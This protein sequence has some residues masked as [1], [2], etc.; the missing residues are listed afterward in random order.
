MREARYA[1]TK[2]PRGHP[3]EHPGGQLEELGMNAAELG[4]QLNAPSN[5]VTA[6]GLD[7]PTR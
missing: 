3:G 5:R 7:I 2:T 6:T 4:R 1:E